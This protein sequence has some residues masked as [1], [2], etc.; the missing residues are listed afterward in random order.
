MRA[1][2]YALAKTVRPDWDVEI[3]TDIELTYYV[4]SNLM[5][6]QY[7]YGGSPQTW[8]MWKCDR[9]LATH[10]LFDRVKNLTAGLRLTN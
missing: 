10:T 2:A 1:S 9:A 8:E 4:H 6:L 7:S 3:A 5:C